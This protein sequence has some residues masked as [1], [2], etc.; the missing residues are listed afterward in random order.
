MQD[1]KGHTISDGIYYLYSLEVQ[2][3]AWVGCDSGLSSFKPQNKNEVHN[4]FT[5]GVRAPLTINT[6]SQD[7]GE[8]NAET[9]TTAEHGGCQRGSNSLAS[10]LYCG[11]ESRATVRLSGE[12]PQCI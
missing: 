6:S 12:S 7:Q 1:S 9:Q 2:N 8:L 10:T 3:I 5:Q 4:A 11:V